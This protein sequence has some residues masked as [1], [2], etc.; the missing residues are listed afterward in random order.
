MTRYDLEIVQNPFCYDLGLFILVCDSNLIRKKRIPPYLFLI[1]MGVLHSVDVSWNILD[2]IYIT[3][4]S[5]S[6]LCVCES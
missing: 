2:H 4:E 5:G 3:W 1:P 6:C